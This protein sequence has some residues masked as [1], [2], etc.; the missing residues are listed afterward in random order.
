M[1]ARKQVDR[2]RSLY[3]SLMKTLLSH[4]KTTIYASDSKAVPAGEK[5]VEEKE[6]SDVAPMA[7]VWAFAMV[8][9]RA[10]T[11]GDDRFAFVPFMVSTAV[12]KSLRFDTVRSGS[13]KY[14][15]CR[16]NDSQGCR[17]FRCRFF[18]FSLFSAICD[19]L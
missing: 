11:A 10:F 19:V 1:R 7:L 12:P 4:P 8:R 17:R 18:P 15:A 14:G 5:G 3:P 2:L 13:V 6:E 16:K 9:S